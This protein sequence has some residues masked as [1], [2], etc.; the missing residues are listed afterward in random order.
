MVQHQK[1]QHNRDR[2]Y[3]T[4]E[5]FLH[6]GSEPR[7]L[8]EEKYDTWQWNFGRSPRFDL[9]N[10]CRFDGGGL[11]VGLSVESGHITEIAFFGDFLSLTPPD[12][13]AAALRGC[14]FRR[15]DVQAVLERFSLRELFGGITATEVLDTIFYAGDL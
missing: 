5:V 3:K 12:A 10:K 7:K 2:T 11:E 8:Q 4:L 15:A 13:L 6:S 14:A 9:A 1:R